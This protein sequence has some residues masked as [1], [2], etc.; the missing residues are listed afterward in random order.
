MDTLKYTTPS[1]FNPYTI[2]EGEGEIN[3]YH[4]GK[5][6]ERDLT[7]EESARAIALLEECVSRRQSVANYGILF[8]FF[9][10]TFIPI[11][12]YFNHPIDNLYSLAFFDLMFLFWVYTTKRGW[13]KR[14]SSACWK[15]KEKDEKTGATIS[16]QKAH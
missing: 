15:R 10:A 14:D 2:H 5:V 8:A 4:I 16:P 3:T 12:L 11:V 13:N 9:N 6:L 1:P 7:G